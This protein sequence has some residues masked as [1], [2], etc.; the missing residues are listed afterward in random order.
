MI[1]NLAK[2]E[3][4]AF[5]TVMTIV[6]GVWMVLLVKT[7]KFVLQREF[8]LQVCSTFLCAHMTPINT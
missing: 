7:V 2:M 5:Q 4:S 3:E 1:P 8:Q 6:V